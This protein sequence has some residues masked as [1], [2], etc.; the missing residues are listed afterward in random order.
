MP[1]LWEYLYSDDT[2]KPERM[3]TSLGL[4]EGLL[5]DVGNMDFGEIERYD[6]NGLFYQYSDDCVVVSKDVQ[7]LH[8]LLRWEPSLL[9]PCAECKNDRPFFRNYNTYRPINPMNPNPIFYSFLEDSLTACDQEQENFLNLDLTNSHRTQLA[10]YCINGI[11]RRCSTFSITLSCSNN[12]NHVI[13]SFYT[14]HKAIDYCNEP[15][16]ESED[17]KIHYSDLKNYLILEKVGQD[18]SMADLQLFDI[19]K[20][21]NILSNDRFC[22]FRM[23][24]GLYAAG[25][26]CGSLFYLRRVFESVIKMLEDE[27]RTL[28]EW[29]EKKYHDG[30]FNEKMAY[31]ES[32]GKKIIPDELLNIKTQ[33]YGG[34]SAGVHGMTDIEA[35]KLFPYFKFAIEMILDE[36]ILQKDKERK[37]KE[38]RKAISSISSE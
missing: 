28:P 29:D 21:R 35:T 30:K 15:Q 14:I 26:G 36:R 3:I 8:K 22:D 20:Y 25:V 33:I 34:L 11:L 12:S 38:L 17:Y 32:L 4:Y 7:A 2:F 23:A 37:V 19:K 9:L 31:I 24:V 13:S 18:P 10:D 6:K 1:K 27:C 5:I 16:S